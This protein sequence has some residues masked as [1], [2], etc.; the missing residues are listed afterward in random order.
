MFRYLVLAQR[1]PHFDPEAAKAHL[2]FLQGLRNGGVLELSGPYSDKSGGAYLI[3][4]ENLD[5]AMA[6][7]HQDPI[8]TSGGWEIDVREW[9]A[10]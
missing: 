2:V 6:I 4:A 5:A 8:H 10:R 1:L 7:V 9:D 3:H